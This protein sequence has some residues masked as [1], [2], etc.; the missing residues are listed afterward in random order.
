MHIT[1]TFRIYTLKLCEN[2]KFI[3]FVCTARA[4]LKGKMLKTKVDLK[5]YRF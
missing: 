4:L 1:I 3:E 5:L 2:S